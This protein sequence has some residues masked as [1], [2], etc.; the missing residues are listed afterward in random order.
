M[1]DHGIQSRS[2]GSQ[3]ALSVAQPPAAVED[4]P[5]ALTP[6]S[7]FANQPR[8]TSRTSTKGR[9]MREAEPD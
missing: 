2:G 3:Q 1:A 9:T 8:Q 6:Y 5:H 7:L 4:H